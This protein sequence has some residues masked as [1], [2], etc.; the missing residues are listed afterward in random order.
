MSYPRTKIYNIEY[1]KLRISFKVTPEES[2][3]TQI[4]ILE[5]VF[6]S[7]LTQTINEDTDAEN[8]RHREMS[9]RELNILRRNSITGENLLKQ[10]ILI[11]N[12]HQ[13]REWLNDRRLSHPVPQII[14]SEALT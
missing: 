5:K 3:K 1:R 8:A 9:V 6:R 14:C 2:L 13:M 11:Y 7:P 4:N 12:Q 10:L